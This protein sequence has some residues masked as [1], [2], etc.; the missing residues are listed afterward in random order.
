MSKYTVYISC[1]WL[2]LFAVVLGFNPTLSAQSEESFQVN[3][4]LWEEEVEKCTF[5]KELKKPEEGEE[6]EYTPVEESDFNPESIVSSLKVLAYIFIGLL[7]IL[8]L[9]FLLQSGI[10]KGNKSIKNQGEWLDKIEQIE[11]DLENNKLDGFI[12]QALKEGA[13]AIAIRLQYLLAIQ[14]LNEG[15][16]IVW[17]KQKTN[18]QYL[19]E[20]SR[21]PYALNFKRATLTFEY[22]WYSDQNLTSSELKHYF[23]SIA[24]NVSS[25]VSQLKDK[26]HE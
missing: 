21:S 12:E 25:I 4:K 17:K 5:S 8:L 14:Q 7:L 15:G 2:L 9:Y 3:Q 11:E 23:N 24:K 20:L 22:I 10:F 6:I 16:A 13:W 18:G 1:R 26:P 19:K